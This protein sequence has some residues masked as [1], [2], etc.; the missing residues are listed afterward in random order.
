MKSND[1]RFE[2]EDEVNV[3]HKT[4]LYCFLPVNFFRN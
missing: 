3:A 1:L 4:C 2:C